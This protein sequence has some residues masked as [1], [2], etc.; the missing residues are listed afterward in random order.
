MQSLTV[1]RE[2]SLAVVT[3]DRPDQLN[4]LTVDLIDELLET[5]DQAETDHHALVLTGRGRAFC[6]GADLSGMAP[7]AADETLG[8]YVSR[9]LRTH[10]NEL[11]RR[12]SMASV[13]I[14][15][16][17][18]GVTAGGGIGLALVADVTLASRSASF[19]N[20]FAQ[21]L[22]VVPD[23]GSSWLVPAAIGRNRARAWAL[24]GERIDAEAAAAWGMVYEVVEDD[25]LLDRASELATKL[26]R[27]PADTMA[28]VRLTA[29]LSGIPFAA[30][31]EREWTLQ[32]VLIDQGYLVEG[33][34]AFFAGEAPD[35]HSRT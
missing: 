14:V 25:R 26:L 31:L 35:F 17:V 30:A 13:P 4:A 28:A 2:G 27:L 5:L 9:L 12:L 34:R 32:E 1:A 8:Q 24:S 29:D 3:L 20:V 18:N 11:P 21:Q 33:V 10:F 15:S 7:E 6:A 23:M 22:G 19:V 16:A